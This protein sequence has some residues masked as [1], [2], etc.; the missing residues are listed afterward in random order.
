MYTQEK[1]AEDGTVKLRH[2]WCLPSPMD[3][4]IR[5]I[6]RQVFSMTFRNDE[7]DHIVRR[8]RRPCNPPCECGVKP[9][10][11]ARL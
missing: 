2:T 8:L 7:V 3:R 6:S 9:L 5:T 1:R 11:E 10:V 4:A